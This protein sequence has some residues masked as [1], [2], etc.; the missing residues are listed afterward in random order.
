MAY[1]VAL[2]CGTGDRPAGWRFWRA[3][4]FIKGRNER[5]P[6]VLFTEHNQYAVAHG[7]QRRRRAGFRTAGDDLRR[8]TVE[9][10]IPRASAHGGWR[11][12]DNMVIRRADQRATIA[13]LKWSGRLRLSGVH[14]I[15]GV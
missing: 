15:E 7:F 2:L 10:A 1:A 14:H 11:G 3:K 9:P 8:G 12:A 4:R 13:A 5:N 6:S